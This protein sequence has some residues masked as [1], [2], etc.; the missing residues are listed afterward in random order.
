MDKNFTKGVASLAAVAA[1]AAGGY[2]VSSGSNNTSTAASNG[3]PTARGAPQGAAGR[4]PNGVP[5][6]TPPAGFVTPATGTA[7]T[8]A[9]AAALTKYPGTVERVMKTPTGGYVVH[10]IKSDGSEVHVL[11][12]SVFKVTGTETGGPG[13]M[14]GPPTSS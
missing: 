5:S 14:T 13:G 4:A 6:G 7:A 11:L 10:V 12:N 1:I 9:K 2:A 3:M 8:N